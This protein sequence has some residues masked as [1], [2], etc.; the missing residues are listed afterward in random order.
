MLRKMI[1]TKDKNVKITFRCES[2]LGDW[3]LARSREMGLT[4]SAFCRTVLFQNMYGEK[5]LS[6]ILANKP[7]TSAETAVEKCEQVN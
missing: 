1:Y 2:A 4:P 6:T 3:V 5:T 7:N